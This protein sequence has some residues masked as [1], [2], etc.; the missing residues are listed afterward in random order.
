MS[1]INDDPRIKRLALALGLTTH[2]LQI[3]C[4]LGLIQQQLVNLRGAIADVMDAED[5]DH[6][7]IVQIMELI[8]ESVAEQL[9]DDVVIPDD[10]GEIADE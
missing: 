8:P 2:M 9:C 6:N 4:P 10:I 1:L 3:G 7:Q 5:L